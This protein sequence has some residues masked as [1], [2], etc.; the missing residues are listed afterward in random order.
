MRSAV[1]I[2]F[3][4]GILVFLGWSVMLDTVRCI[5]SILVILMGKKMKRKP[6]SHQQCCDI[7]DISG[8]EAIAIEKRTLVATMRC[9]VLLWYV[10]GKAFWC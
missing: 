1:L 2:W 5:Q 8:P 6:F 10:S 7:A 4:R 9:G 3:A